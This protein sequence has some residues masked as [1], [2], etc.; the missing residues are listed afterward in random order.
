MGLSLLHRRIIFRPALGAGASSLPRR[1]QRYRE[2]AGQLRFHPGEQFNLGGRMFPH[3]S[4]SLLHL[5]KLRRGLVDV[6]SNVSGQ[7]PLV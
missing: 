7:I 1:E 3:A 2:G 5:P 6:E 4:Q